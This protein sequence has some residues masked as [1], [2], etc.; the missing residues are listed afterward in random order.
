MKSEC[1]INIYYRL[2]EII[3][4]KYEIL[5]RVSIIFDL[6]HRNKFSLQDI[7]YT[8]YKGFNQ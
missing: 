4:N 3:K 5:Y 6:I 1:N 2:K 8:N 7:A